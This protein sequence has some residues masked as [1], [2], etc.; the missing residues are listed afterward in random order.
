MIELNAGGKLVM[1]KEERGLFEIL[2]AMSRTR[3]QLDLKECIGTYEFGVIERS[4]Y[5][6]RWNSLVGL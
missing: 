5:C 3:P 2:I 6:V 4:L 1:I